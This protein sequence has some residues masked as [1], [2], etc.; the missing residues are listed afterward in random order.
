[1]IKTLLTRI[2]ASSKTLLRSF[3]QTSKLSPEDVEFLNKITLDPHGV[4]ST[5]H[6]DLIPH[7][8]YDTKLHS[9]LWTRLTINNNKELVEVA[10]SDFSTFNTLALGGVDFDTTFRLAALL[11]SLE[12]LSPNLEHIKAAALYPNAPRKERFDAAFTYN[13]NKLY[14]PKYIEEITRQHI[15][16]RFLDN[17]GQ[18]VAPKKPLS[19]YSFSVGAREIMMIENCLRNIWQTEY[20]CSDLQVYNFFTY[21][22]ANCIAYALADDDLPALRFRKN[23]ICSVLDIG[24]LRPRPLSEKYLWRK[25]ANTC[26]AGWN[27]IE[28]DKKLSAPLNLF[29]LGPKTLPIVTKTGKI[30]PDTFHSLPHYME[31]IISVPWMHESLL[32]SFKEFDYSE[33]DHIVKD[34]GV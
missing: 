28:G 21:L 30:I 20:E 9:T 10:K 29:L 19:F 34:M 6:V 2:T 24:V 7:P 33:A 23:V 26:E 31:G 18:L 27:E 22:Q 17:S 8:D 4:V 32:R 16:P 11:K 13:K 12:A 3:S 14:Y 25:P 1:M 5:G 15:L